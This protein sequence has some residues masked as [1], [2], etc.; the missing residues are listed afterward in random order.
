[1]RSS[2]PL[3]TILGAAVLAAALITVPT[4]AEQCVD[5]QGIEHC[6]LGEA[7]L[8]LSPEGLEWIKIGG[9]GTKPGV[10]SHLPAGTT[11]WAAELAFDP[12]AG[13]GP[14]MLSSA[15]ADGAAVARLRLD[16]V[17]D[18]YLQGVPGVINGYVVSLGFSG[19]ASGS[20][21]SVL[22]YSG[23]VL[24]GAVGGLASDDQLLQT[25]LP[26]DDVPNP[27]DI[28]IF[29]WPGP[30]PFLPGPG[31]NDGP[32]MTFGIDLQS[33]AC[34][35]S[36]SNAAGMHVQLPT[37]ALVPADEIRFVEEVSLNNVYPDFHGMELMLGGD[38]M[39]IASEISNGI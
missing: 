36:A 9:A 4:Q 5:F 2:T 19:A 31:G 30:G 13:P 23:G 10:A 20:T 17:D 35:F 21:Y 1:M 34:F 28:I 11:F 39:T 14:W 18:S 33:G 24:Q 27:W 6:P 38:R 7:S 32:I 22:V 26:T 3:T 16:E 15:I 29:D 37:G 25:T 8:E 12:H